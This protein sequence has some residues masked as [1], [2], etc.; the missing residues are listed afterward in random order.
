MTRILALAAALVLAAC[1]PAQESRAPAEAPQDAP[2]AALTVSGG[3][4]RASLGR[5]PHTG[6]YVT[7]ANA[8]SR[9]DRLVGAAC[10]CAGRVELH[11]V[12]TDGGVMRM[13]PVEAMEVPAGGALSLAPGGDHLMFL[14]LTAP[15]ADG[16]SADVTLTFEHAGE[17]TVRLPVRAAAPAADGDHGGHG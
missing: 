17:V 4:V 2:G 6:G 14:D 12:A 5:N 16:Q 8:G 3:W 9:A 11:T 13:S 15:L 10:D 1:Q 7:V